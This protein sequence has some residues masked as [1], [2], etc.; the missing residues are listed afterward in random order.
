M[1][2]DLNQ[3]QF[4]GR[5]GN[6]V[7]VR[8]MPNGNAVTNFSLACGWKTKDKEGVE[9]VNIVAFGKLGE[10]CGK[11]LAKGSQVFISGKMRTQKWEDQ[12]GNTRYK[13]EIVANDMQMLGSKGDNQQQAP[14]QA[15]AP[16]DSEDI[17][18]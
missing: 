12:Q 13:T 1:S 6:D 9:W 15:P 7:D 2:N 17:P 18:F 4:I 16:L 14:Q 8:Y 10:I 3:C 5:L 11:Y